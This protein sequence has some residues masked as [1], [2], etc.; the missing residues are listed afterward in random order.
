M[1]KRKE[2]QQFFIC[3]EGECEERYLDR[4]KKIINDSEGAKYFVDFQY[5]KIK[6]F[7][8]LHKRPAN[9]QSDYIFCFWDKEGEF[10]GDD[11]AFYKIFA[12]LR[13]L[14]KMWN[15]KKIEPGYSH[16]CFE[17]WILLHR[18]DFNRFL[19]DKKQYLKH[20]NEAYNTSYKT[21][22][23]YKEKDNFCSLMETITLED[24]FAA[25]RRADMIRQFHKRNQSVPHPVHETKPYTVYGT[26][27]DLLI[28][29]CIRFILETCGIKVPK[30]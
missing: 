13:K 7:S 4:L 28:H 30:S 16:L 20:L 18:V 3:R 21:L 23:E 12:E 1:V 11:H 26:N 2:K 15:R 14:N 24:V 5:G 9:V 10:C 17:L 25:I 8:S 6:D 29:D 19:S 27:P 22:R